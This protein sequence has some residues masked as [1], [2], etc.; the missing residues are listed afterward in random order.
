MLS[1]RVP[2]NISGSSPSFIPW[3]SDQKAFLMR[4]LLFFVL[5]IAVLSLDISSSLTLYSA[6]SVCTES[7]TFGKG[8]PRWLVQNLAS[9]R[10][11][12]EEVD[13]NVIINSTINARSYEL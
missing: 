2:E 3:V 6:T 12:G 4:G 13:T 5:T 10:E 8:L 1:V 11:W 9:V 7:A